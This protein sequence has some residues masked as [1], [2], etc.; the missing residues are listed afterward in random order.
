MIYKARESFLMDT[1]QKNLTRV[2]EAVEAILPK[3]NLSGQ[4]SL[5]IMQNGDEFWAIDMALAESSAFYE[6]VPPELR[7]PTEENWLPQIEGPK[8]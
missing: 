6:T 7:A 3:L 8:E 4:W 5:D 2:L 1:Y